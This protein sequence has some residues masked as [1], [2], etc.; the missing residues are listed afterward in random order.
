[1][2]TLVLLAIFSLLLLPIQSFAEE[3]VREHTY[4]AGDDDSK[5]DSRK[6]AMEQI[7]LELLSE[8]GIHIKS[9]WELWESE[10][11]RRITEDIETITA[12]I[13]QTD[14]LGESWDGFNY[15]VKAKLEVDI[16]DA[17]RKLKHEVTERNK[18]KKLQR[19][20]YSKEQEIERLEAQVQQQA[21]YQPKQRKRKKNPDSR[22]VLRQIYDGILGIDTRPFNEQYHHILHPEEYK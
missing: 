12:G 8:V 21:K 5:N 4:R 2:R 6:K 3:F 17:R 20:L 9:G 19:E 22:S 7:Q 1:M 15:Y 16:A 14:I 10:S 11:D 13:T 18:R